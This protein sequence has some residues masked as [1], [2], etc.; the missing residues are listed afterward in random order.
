MIKLCPAQKLLNSTLSTVGVIMLYVYTAQLDTDYI[1]A[2]QFMSNVGNM[3]LWGVAI[4]S[5]LTLSFI[6][7]RDKIKKEERRKRMKRVGR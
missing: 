6:L 5:S 7:L 3:L 2:E 4:W 1:T